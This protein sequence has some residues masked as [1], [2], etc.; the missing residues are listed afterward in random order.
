M[1]TR[2]KLHIIRVRV[3]NGHIIAHNCKGRAENLLLLLSLLL[4]LLNANSRR[5]TVNAFAC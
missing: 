2:L 5:Y 3:G 4:R 1:I